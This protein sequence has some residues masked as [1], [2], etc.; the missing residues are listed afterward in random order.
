MWAG[1]L[2][3]GRIPLDMGTIAAVCPFKQAMY[4]DAR[5][6]RSFDL[7]SEEF[8]LIGLSMVLLAI[9]TNRAFLVGIGER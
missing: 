8:T 7:L 3:V 4:E 5:R 6:R 9:C 2:A 1:T